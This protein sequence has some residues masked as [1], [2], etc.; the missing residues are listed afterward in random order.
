MNIR[1]ITDYIFLDHKDPAG[2]IALVFGTWN[3][4]Q[5]SIEKAAAYSFAPHRIHRENWSKSEY[6][7]EKV[8]EEMKK[9]K[10]IW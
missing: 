10:H 2:D 3:A 9:L 5:E 6:G 8:M 7:R 1:K 4:W